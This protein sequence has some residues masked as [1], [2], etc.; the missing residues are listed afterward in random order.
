MPQRVQGAEQDGAALLRDESVP[1]QALDVCVCTGTVLG[2]VRLELCRTAV[3]VRRRPRG[4]M[5]GMP[6]LGGFGGGSGA[7]D[8]DDRRDV[9]PVDPVSDP[10]QQRGE[11]QRPAAGLRCQ[12]RIA[13][14]ASRQQRQDRQ[15]DGQAQTPRDGRR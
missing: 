15:A 7:G 2:E 13:D 14:A 8:V 11:Q 1:R 5:L 10:E 3:R 9:V 12:A 6:F 4:V